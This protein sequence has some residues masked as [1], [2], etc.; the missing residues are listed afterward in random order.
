MIANILK[1]LLLLFKLFVV[2]LNLFLLELGL[3]ITSLINRLKKKFIFDIG[4]EK[5]KLNFSYLIL[6]VVL[7]FFEILVFLNSFLKSCFA[8]L[9]AL[10]KNLLNIIFKLLAIFFFFFGGAKIENNFNNFLFWC[11]RN[12]KKK[13]LNYKSKI[14]AYRQDNYKTRYFLR[15]DVDLRLEDFKDF[16]YL[17]QIHEWRQ[18]VFLYYHRFSFFFSFIVQFSKLISY[19]SKAFYKLLKPLFEIV[20]S[21]KVARA[22]NFDYSIFKKVIW[23]VVF[24]WATNIQILVFHFCMFFWISVKFW[25]LFLEIYRFIFLIFLSTTFKPLVDQLDYYLLMFNNFL[26]LHLYKIK[27]DYLL[28]DVWRPG[29]RQLVKDLA[30]TGLSSPSW[31]HYSFM[32][33]RNFNKFED[34]FLN[35]FFPLSDNDINFSFNSCDVFIDLFKINWNSF[36][37]RV[38]FKDNVQYLG[39]RELIFPGSNFIKPVVTKISEN[40]DIEAMALEYIPK[41]KY[42][43]LFITKFEHLGFPPVNS[44]EHYEISKP[45]YDSLNDLIALR[46]PSNRLLEDLVLIYPE[47]DQIIVYIYLIFVILIYVIGYLFINVN[48]QLHKFGFEFKL[49]NIFNILGFFFY[50]F[51][52]FLFCF[53]F[54]FTISLVYHFL[55][56]FFQFLFFFMYIINRLLQLFEVLIHFLLNTYIYGTWLLVIKAPYFIFGG[57]SKFLNFF[58]QRVLLIVRNIFP[59]LYYPYLGLARIIFF[60]LDFLMNFLIF[61]FYYDFTLVKTWLIEILAK[62]VR[63]LPYFFRVSLSMSF[64]FFKGPLIFFYSF[65]TLQFFYPIWEIIGQKYVFIVHTIFFTSFVFRHPFKQEAVLD[66]YASVP[67]HMWIFLFY[68]WV[69]IPWFVFNFTIFNR[70]SLRI[71]SRFYIMYFIMFIYAYRD[72]VIGVSDLIARTYNVSE[73]HSDW[74]PV[75]STI[76]PPVVEVRDLPSYLS[77]ED[78]KYLNDIEKKIHQTFETTWNLGKYTLDDQQF[79]SEDQYYK[80]FFDELD[81]AIEEYK[82]DNAN[83]E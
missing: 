73:I 6:L 65:V 38:V 62:G 40:N 13:G 50:N 58:V 48:L 72:I 55:V 78:I 63:I 17:E 45:L 81:V 47:L 51:L 74:S 41:S 31:T 53:P 34:V 39:I 52:I 11:F 57:L 7:K 16:K 18:R 80:D 60:G 4:S 26:K 1:I 43:Y 23:N 56:C 14:G 32:S 20:S 33:Y 29:T 25:F 3:D 22:L 27:E 79:K 77:E 66:V 28:S 61:D 21:F 75:E 67:N 9:V 68:V 42:D 24:S 54:I 35:R 46:Y 82:R 19:S 49:S 37:D 10:N 70:S 76:N 83:K 44:N 8:V 36:S 64:K 15:R 69:G 5:G 71:Y 2:N 30:D 59:V 12:C